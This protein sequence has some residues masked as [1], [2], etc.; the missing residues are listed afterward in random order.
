M[1]STFMMRALKVRFAG[2]THI[3]MK[4]AHNEDSLFLPDVERLAVVADG[5]GGH[6]SGEVASKMAVE[7]LAEHFRNTRDEAE[8]TWPYRLDPA[9]RYEITRLINGIQLAN[10]KIY[11]RAQ[12]DE[13]CHGMGTT[14]VATLFCDDRVLIGHVGDSRVYRLRDG[15]LTQL[16]EDHSLLNDYIK[17]KR[18]SA[19][20]IG[21]FQHKNVIVRALGMKESVQVDVMSDTFRLNDVYLMCS[22]GL[23]GMIDDDGLA[24][25]MRSETDLDRASEA[26]IAKANQNGGV[27][28]ITCVLARLEP[29]IA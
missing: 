28:N 10:L 22:D 6:A 2:E 21:K 12:T 9:D 19:E 4:R 26:L 17:M 24:E 27:D 13:K 25:V 29:L 23:S 7:I 5:M 1:S 15:K 3:G 20:E 11:D 8:I 18:M 14:I 16:T